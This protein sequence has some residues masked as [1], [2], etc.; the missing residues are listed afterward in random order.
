MK[1]DDDPVVV[2]Q[3]Y[4]TS[5]ENVWNAITEI[6]LM[7]QWYFDNIPTFK[8]EVGFETQFNIE[9][10]GRNFLHLWRV[11]EVEPMKKLTY[12]WKFKEYPGDSYVVWELF[13]QDNSTTLR[14]T[15][16]VEEDFPDD[17]PEFQRESCVGGWQYFINGRLKEFLEKND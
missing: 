13:G 10:E 7:R 14:L 6:D 1:K 15:V 5:I 16:V 9:N 2:E 4:T 3:T 17:I 12:T 11:T 8:P